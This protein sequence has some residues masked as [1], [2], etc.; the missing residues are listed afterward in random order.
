VK[1]QLDHQQSNKK[2]DKPKS[3]KKKLGIGEKELL[4]N[5]D[6][7]IELFCVIRGNFKSSCSKQTWLI[8]IFS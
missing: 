8:V 4:S 2:A 6:L 1:S 5:G 3:Y 7:L